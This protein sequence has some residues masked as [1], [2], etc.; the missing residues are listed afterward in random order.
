MFLLI[1]TAAMILGQGH[2]KD[3]QYIFFRH[4]FSLS[5]VPKVQHQQLRR[6]K[7]KLLI[8]AVVVDMNWHSHPRQGWLHYRAR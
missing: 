6:D 1:S 7:H 8:V 5:H 4:V 3:I 2:G